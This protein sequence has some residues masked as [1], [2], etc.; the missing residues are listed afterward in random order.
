MWNHSKI[1]FRIKNTQKIDTVLSLRDQLF[2]CWT[3]ADDGN[4]SLL[5]FVMIS[6]QKLN[7]FSQ[8]ELSAVDRHIMSQ[9]TEESQCSFVWV[10]PFNKATQSPLHKKWQ[11][12]CHKI[13]SNAF[14]YNKLVRFGATHTKK[15]LTFEQT[16][17]YMCSDCDLFCYFKGIYDK[18][19]IKIAEMEHNITKI[20]CKQI[21]IV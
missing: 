13:H 9:N 17:P 12:L 1:K 10:A 20:S 21:R 3:T 2:H 19:Y 18:R 6:S 7:N 15:L 16:S 14:S 8:G 5:M 11:T 4:D